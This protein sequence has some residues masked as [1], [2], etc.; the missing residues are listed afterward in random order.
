MWSGVA[1]E[2][3]AVLLEVGASMSASSY[4][5]IPERLKNEPPRCPLCG[6]VLDLSIDTSGAPDG[7]ALL[8]IT[9]L[10]LKHVSQPHALPIP[11]D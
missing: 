5:A 3:G 9:A 1:H 6:I 7:Q 11:T 8:T 4:P 10:S 2:V